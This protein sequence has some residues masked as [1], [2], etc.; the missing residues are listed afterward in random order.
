MQTDLRSMLL[1]YLEQHNTMT[2]ATSGEDGP[3]AA[4]VF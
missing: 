1:D 2:I 4:G 3:A